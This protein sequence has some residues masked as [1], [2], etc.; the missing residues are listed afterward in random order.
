MCSSFPTTLASFFIGTCHVHSLSWVFALAFPSAW[1]D[2]PLIIF[3]VNSVTAFKSLVR[4]HLGLITPL[5]VKFHNHAPQHSLL[6]Q[7]VP[8]PTYFAL[9]LC[10]HS[11][12]C[13]LTFHVIY[14]LGC[15]FSVCFLVCLRQAEQCLVN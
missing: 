3:T 6:A 2:L 9:F 8:S 7:Y 11:S 14:L 10:F 4:C 5:Y 13:L 15:L 12:F 1:N